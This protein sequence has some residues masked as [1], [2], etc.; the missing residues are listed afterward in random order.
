MGV[1][2][3]GPRALPAQQCLHSAGAGLVLLMRCIQMAAPTCVMCGARHAS[4]IG[5]L[6]LVAKNMHRPAAG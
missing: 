5:L 4:H 2:L 6:G 1:A 3:A